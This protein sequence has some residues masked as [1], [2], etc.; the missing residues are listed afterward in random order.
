MARI[1]TKKAAGEDTTSLEQ[2][3]KKAGADRGTDIGEII[4]SIRKSNKQ[5]LGEAGG[6]ITDVVTAGAPSF[7][8]KAV[9]GAEAA[10]AGAKSFK[11]RSQ[12]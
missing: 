8:G 2:L 6:V 7:L 12:A 4:P 3:L 1:K 11:G 9:K 10:T 5:I